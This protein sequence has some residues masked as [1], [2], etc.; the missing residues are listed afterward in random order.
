MQRVDSVERL[1]QIDTRC[2]RGAENAASWRVPAQG[3]SFDGIAILL[4]V[5]VG[6]A[7]LL[8]QASRG[9]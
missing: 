1:P 3:T 9:R 2:E 8:M 5:F 7:G 4:S 6:A